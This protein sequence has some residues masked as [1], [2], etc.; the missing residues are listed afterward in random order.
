LRAIPCNFPAT[1]SATKTVAGS[2]AALPGQELGA[3]LEITERLDAH[4]GYRGR[5]TNMIKLAFFVVP[6]K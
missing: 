6:R 3:F 5:I 2:P 4:V 1:V